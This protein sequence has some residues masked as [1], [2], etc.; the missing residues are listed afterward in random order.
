[1]ELSNSTIALTGGGTAG[2]VMVNI[3]LESE[4]K[5]HFSKIIYIGS[6]NG[7]EK[8]L[9]K[10]RTSYEYIS[11]PTV[12]LN[13]SNI[14]KNILV[15]MRLL[16][17][18]DAA[19]EILK[20]YKPCIVFSKGGYVGLPVVMAAKSLKI[21]SLSHESDL[22]MGLA[23]KISKH[24]SN[25]ILTSFKITA[26]KN[27]KKCKFCSMPLKISKLTKSQALEKLGIATKLPVLLVTGG[28]LGA[29]TINEFIFK[30]ID[31]ITKKYYV[32][33]LV[34]KGNLNKKLTNKHNYKQIEFSNDMWTIFKATDFAI[35]R[36]G[37]NTI[38][39]LLSNNILTIFVP[40]PKSVSR[41]DQIENANYLE[42]QGLSKTILQKNLNIESLLG[43]LETLNINSKSIKNA[44]KKQNI[45]DGTNNI[46]NE[47]LKA[48]KKV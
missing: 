36:A 20:K 9:I 25:K 29:K 48:A 35:S 4:L 37:A 8:E 7:I 6:E 46:I 23:N 33:H 21:P 26:D 28:S 41:G 47:I 1:M 3:N 10:K 44:I 32:L 12:K 19:K 27:G 45:S 17:A 34:G 38:L 2:H 31:E 42:K 30:N 13:R 14:L 39:E 24:F 5:K 43:T 22:T 16:E 11:I 15:P 18:S 40:L